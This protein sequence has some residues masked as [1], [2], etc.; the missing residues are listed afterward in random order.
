MR[1]AFYQP[2]IPQ[3]LGAAIRIAACFDTPLEIVGPFG[4]PL[5]DKA[6]RRSA[7]DY[8]LQADLVRHDGWAAFQ[9]APE[10]QSSRLVLFTT[11]GAQT[12]D[13]FVFE[14]NDTL[15]FGRES[16]GAPEEVHQAADARCYIPMAQGTRS[17]NVAVT[18]GIAL[19]E[20][21]RQLSLLNA[22]INA[23]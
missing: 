19:F 22:S 9:N 23:D 18:A 5:T 13:S 8:A 1:L 3:N 7:M 14:P 4:F 17:L 6:L 2:D 11:Q 16:A 21:R 15:L 20:A 12:I 10:R